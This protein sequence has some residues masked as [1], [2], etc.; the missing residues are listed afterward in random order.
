MASSKKAIQFNEK[1]LTSKEVKKLQEQYGKNE[2]HKG[3]KK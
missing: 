2:I 3:K 1:G